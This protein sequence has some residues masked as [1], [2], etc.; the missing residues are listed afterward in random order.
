LG[1]QYDS[2]RRK[3][4]VRWHEDGQKRSRRF[5]AE[6]EAA[7]FDAALERRPGRRS[8]ANAEPSQ[9]EATN[10]S[11]QARGEGVY[12]DRTKSGMRWRCVFRQSDGTLT[13]RRG[14][15]SRTAAVRARRRL[16]EAVSRGEVK[17]AREDFASSGH[18]SP[19]RSDRT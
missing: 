2:A 19:Q 17:V 1:V 13:S 12:S 4:L 15:T 18:G 10:P 9:R 6:D 16:A 8:R 7:A 5:D 14:Y 11:R 3:F